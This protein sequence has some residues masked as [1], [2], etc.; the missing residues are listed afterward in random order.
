MPRKRTR[1]RAREMEEK[2][3]RRKTI[4]SREKMSNGLTIKEKVDG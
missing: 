4:Q 1:S 3:A 2:N